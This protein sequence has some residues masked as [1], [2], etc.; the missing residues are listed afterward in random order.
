[1]Y[2]SFAFL[3]TQTELRGSVTASDTRV[4]HWHLMHSNLQLKL[5]P[6]YMYPKKFSSHVPIGSNPNLEERAGDACMHVVPD[7]SHRAPSGC[8]GL[9]SVTEQNI[10]WTCPSCLF[11]P[12]CRAA[13]HSVDGTDSCVGQPT[14]TLPHRKLPVCNWNDSMHEVSSER[15]ATIDV[16]YSI[17]FMCSSDS[18]SHASWSLIKLENKSK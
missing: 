9:F 15:P 7:G 5:T 11:H 16:S 13:L 12:L 18:C 17:C 1:M 14:A 6:D 10:S 4:T 2:R 3:Q 8:L